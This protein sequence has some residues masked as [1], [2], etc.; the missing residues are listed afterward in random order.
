MLRLLLGAINTSW[1]CLA[2]FNANGAARILSSTRI[3]HLEKSPQLPEMRVEKAKLIVQTYTHTHTPF[4]EAFSELSTYVCPMCACFIF[5]YLHD[6][7]HI[8][9]L[10]GAR[11]SDLGS[12]TSLPKNGGDIVT[13][14]CSP[15]DYDQH[16]CR[17]TYIYFLCLC[18]NH[19][20]E[21]F[22]LPPSC[23]VWKYLFSICSCGLCSWEF[24]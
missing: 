3:F 17:Y 22:L 6:F 1:H 16:I 21:I 9:P 15:A 24:M 19:D 4:K 23:H 14:S 2:S 18:F 10:F 20:S 8:S 7:C 5:L 13:S 11:S 12:R